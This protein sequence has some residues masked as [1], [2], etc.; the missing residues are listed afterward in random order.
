MTIG[1][2]TLEQ[3]IA[4]LTAGSAP[5]LTKAAEDCQ[6]DAARSSRG[7]NVWLIESVAPHSKVVAEPPTH[8]VQRRRRSL[9]DDPQLRR[10]A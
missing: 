5:T 3:A 6:P 7:G 2:Q 8:L 10:D 4:A 9:A 1:D